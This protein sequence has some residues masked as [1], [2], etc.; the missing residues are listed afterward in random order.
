M[1]DEK[2]SETY[3]DLLLLTQPRV[4]HS[5]DEYHRQ[6]HWVDRIMKLE[7]ANLKCEPRIRIAE[8]LASTV[9]KWEDE[10]SVPVP[11]LS[12]HQMLVY[13]MAGRDISMPDLAQELG[14]PR[15][16]IIEIVMNNRDISRDMARCFADFFDHPI[17]C[18]VDFPSSPSDHH[19]S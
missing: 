10:S 13:T 19:T 3:D 1:T 11:K 16:L 4:V 14:V 8:L 18:Y 15:K 5:I 12:A 2:L 6:S 17:E 9:L 7:G